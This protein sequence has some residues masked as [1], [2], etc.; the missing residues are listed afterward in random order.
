MRSITGSAALTAV[1]IDDHL[2]TS[3]NGR[4]MSVGKAADVAMTGT[5]LKIH[6]VIAKS[7]LKHRTK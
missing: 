3:G 5:I 6:L 4:T 1:R 7:T 2:S